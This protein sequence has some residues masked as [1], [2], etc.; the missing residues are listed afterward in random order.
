VRIIA[1]HATSDYYKNRAQTV[2]TTSNYEYRYRAIYSLVPS[3]Y[4]HNSNMLD[5]HNSKLDTFISYVYSFYN[6]K[7]GL[8]PIASESR[9][10]EA[11]IQYATKQTDTIHFDSVDREAVRTILEPSYDP[12]A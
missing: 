10:K 11:C 1:E 7:D 5:P 12:I 8:Y 6:D 9:I 4:L 2:Y 3:I